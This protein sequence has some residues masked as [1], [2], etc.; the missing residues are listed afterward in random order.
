MKT[1]KKFWLLG[2]IITM[3]FS[4]SLAGITRVNSAS[5]PKNETP[6]DGKG[7]NNTAYVFAPFAWD[8]GYGDVEAYWD[9]IGPK[10]QK[11]ETHDKDGKLF[12]CIQKDIPG[13]YVFGKPII[14]DT[15]KRE[16]TLQIFY[17]I[18]HD[19]T[20]SL[21]T[22]LISGHGDGFSIDA[23]NETPFI[24]VEFLRR[25]CPVP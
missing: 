11:Y 9:N 15:R 13:F 23:E 24:F 2:L 8:L 5:S 12:G 25:I 10:G 19:K 17:E 20:D 14:E 4:L 22:L 7:E 21:A 16:C 6:G 18:I 3:V 1:S